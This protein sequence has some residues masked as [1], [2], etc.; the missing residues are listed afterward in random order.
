[1]IK[2]QSVCFVSVKIYFPS[3]TDGK[4]N[5]ENGVIETIKVNYARKIKNTK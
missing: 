2:K 4:F 1:M 5:N 3:N